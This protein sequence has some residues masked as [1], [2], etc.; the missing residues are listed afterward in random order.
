[1]WF[2]AT[3][4][5]PKLLNLCNTLLKDNKHQKDEDPTPSTPKF[6]P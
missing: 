5:I 3:K 6:K 2:T 1:M 4:V